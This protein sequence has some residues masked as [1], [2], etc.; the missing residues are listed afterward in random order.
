MKKGILIRWIGGAGGDTLCHLLSVKNDLYIN[1]SFHGITKE[2]QTYSWSKIDDEF[3]SFYKFSR[4]I[5]TDNDVKDFKHDLI[6]L[7]KQGVPFVIKHHLFDKEFDAEMRNHVDLVDIGIDISILPFLVRANLEKTPTLELSYLDSNQKRLFIKLDE[8]QSK[9]LVI[10]NVIKNNID[11]MQKFSLHESPLQLRDFF[12][13]TKN[14]KDFFESKG[15][16]IDLESEYFTNWL[17]ANERSKPSVK[18]QR[19]ILEKNYDHDDKDLD[20]IERYVMLALSHNKFK[21][22][23]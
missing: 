10:W 12:T 5:N 22:L 17:Q 18:Y 13:N 11:L 9:Q 19:Y 15:L 20:I 1:A 16:S 14:I 23:D 7:S 3:P 21:F 8:K 2:G 6:K 4:F